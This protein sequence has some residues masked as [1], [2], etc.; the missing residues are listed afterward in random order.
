MALEESSVESLPKQSAYLAVRNTDGD[1]VFVQGVTDGEYAAIKVVMGGRKIASR[2]DIAATN[3]N[4]VNFNIETDGE[5]GFGDAL[6]SDLEVQAII[7]QPH[8][9]ASPPVA[10]SNRWIFKMFTHGDREVDDIF[11]STDRVLGRAASNA[12]FVL[13]S[14]MG[15]VNEEGS[16]QIPCSLYI[17]T[18]DS[19]ATFT[20]KVIF[21]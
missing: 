3:G 11:F 10:I 16:A 2:T 8:N 13:N 15:Y 4:T 19:D 18:G 5:N 6:P 1:F 9:G 17:E 20:V 7:I 21:V 14:K 12:A